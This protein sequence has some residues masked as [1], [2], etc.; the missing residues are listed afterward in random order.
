MT[1]STPRL[2]LTG[3]I[4]T[5]NEQDNLRRTLDRLHWVPEIL[6]IDSGSND[7]TADILREFV[8]QVRVLTRRF[9]SF[10]GQCNYGLDQIDSEWVLS[11]DA[12]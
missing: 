3:L 5:W 11:L 4:L 10:A 9:D 12:D 7:A 6:V 2:P 1:R 8:P